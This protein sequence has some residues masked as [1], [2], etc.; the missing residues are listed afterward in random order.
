MMGTHSR[1]QTLFTALLVVAFGWGAGWIALRGF[2]YSKSSTIAVETENQKAVTLE[3]K[4]VNPTVPEPRKKITIMIGGDIMFDRGIRAIGERAGYDSLFDSSIK[5]LFKSADLVI[6][7]LEGPITDKPSKTLVN[8]KT[9]DSFT[10]TFPPASAEALASAGISVVSLANNHTDNFGSEGY[11][12]TQR[13]LRDAGIEWFGNPWNST[14]TKLSLRTT[15][16]SAVSTIIAKNGVTIALVGYHAFQLGVDRVV[17][18]VRRV[19]GPHVFTI[20]MPHWGEEYVTTPSAKMR[21]Y[22]RA[23]ITAGADAVIAAHPHVIAEQEWVGGAPVYYS[24]GNLLF[25]QYFSE[26]VNRGLIVELDISVDD[27]GVTLDRAITHGTI[28]KPGVGVSLEK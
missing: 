16:D 18:E 23:F 10:F 20:V 4:V 11:F 9:N 22:A 15:P 5:D 28:I 2:E 17:E 19:S 27:S 3:A 12:S 24:L 25:D 13:Y 6:A 7:N 14:S 8:G 21:S 26:Q 1:I